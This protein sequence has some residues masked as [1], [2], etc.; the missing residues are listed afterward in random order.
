MSIVVRWRFAIHPKMFKTHWS[1]LR[2]YHRKWL[3][4]TE[5]CVTCIVVLNWKYINKIFIFWKFDNHCYRKEFDLF[6]LEFNINIFLYTF[7]HIKNIYCKQR[8]LNKSKSSICLCNHLVF[9]RT[10]YK[11]FVFSRQWVYHVIYHLKILANE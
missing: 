4:D 6:W 11:N 5:K 1:S 10:R 8:H 7:F 2:T 3:F 9:L